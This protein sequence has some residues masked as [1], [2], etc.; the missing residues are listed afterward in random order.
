MELIKLLLDE[1]KEWTEVLFIFNIPG[2]IGSRLRNLYMSVR[3]NKC[4]S[5]YSQTGCVVLSPKNISIGKDVSMMRNCH[6]YAH[7]NG[8]IKAGDRLSL[9]NNVMIDA[10]GG[11]KIFI[12]NDV[13]IGPNVVIRASN[14]TYKSKSVPI[15]KQGHVGGE[16]VIEDD[17]WIGANTVLLPK[18][19][20]RKGSVIAAGSVVN[21]EI[22]SNS[23]A[24]GVPAKVIRTD[25]RV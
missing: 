11:G 3:M 13:L 7:D 14:H 22:Q 25:V 15:N 18:T 24:A 21:S 19:I 23:I 6:L 12:G 1:I 2:R 17:V 10:A 20:I 4:G 8:L 5:L 9:N 16:I